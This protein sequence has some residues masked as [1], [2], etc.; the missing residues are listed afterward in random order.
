MPRGVTVLGLAL[1][2]TLLSG[3][4]RAEPRIPD[5]AFVRD[6]SD[7]VWLVLEGR[8][9]RVPIYPATH[10]EVAA[11]PVNGQWLVPQDGTVVLG[12]R[13]VW[14]DADREGDSRTGGVG[15]ANF[16][17]LSVAVLQLS[18]GWLPAYT[19]IR[20]KP[21][22]EYLIIEVRL[23]NT[24]DQTK[25][26]SASDFQVDVEDGSRWDR[27]I[28]RS[29]D[30]LVGTL[31][32]GASTQGWLTFEVPIGRPAVQLIWNARRDYALAIPL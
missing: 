27:T 20:P 3:P 6:A 21:G 16:E 31:A 15:S 5:G 22:M 25:R 19:S 12:S 13:P 28:A 14:L 24:G 1:L 26:Y 7:A 9:V 32:A 18:R 10:D 17:G 29:P 2:I 30:L 8:R 11:I 23:T 4:T